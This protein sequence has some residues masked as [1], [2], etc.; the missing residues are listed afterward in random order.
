METKII[1]NIPYKMVLKICSMLGKNISALSA[2]ILMSIF[3]Q[4]FL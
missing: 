4:Y 3:V 1:T 2:N